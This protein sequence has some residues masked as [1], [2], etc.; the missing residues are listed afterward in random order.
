MSAEL[1]SAW[2]AA[3]HILQLVAA[4]GLVEAGKGPVVRGARAVVDW[5]HRH[6]P[7]EAQPELAAVLASPAP[8]RARNALERQIGALLE[9]HPELLDDLCALLKRETAGGTTQT[10]TT[11]D[12]AQAAQN[13]GNNATFNFNR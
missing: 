9:A 4:H 7:P 3:T 5:L 12:N 8:G 1:A 11:G 10:M 6:L 2:E 13:T